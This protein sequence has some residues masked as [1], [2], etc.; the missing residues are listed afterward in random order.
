M[1]PPVWP[2]SRSASPS[3][4]PRPC[5]PSSCLVPTKALSPPVTGEH[6]QAHL[7]HAHRWGRT[8]PMLGGLPLRHATLSARGAAAR[9]EVGESGTSPRGCSPSDWLAC[10]PPQHPSTLL[11]P[12]RGA[13][14]CQPQFRQNV[15]RTSLILTWSLLTRLV[16]MALPSGRGRSYLSCRLSSPARPLTGTLSAGLQVLGG[17]R[18]CGI[19][20]LL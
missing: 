14:T 2:W 8:Q 5:R 9:A 19:L 7:S 6:H 15:T 16:R 4:C 20:S 12:S 1:S 18:L 11:P 3:P 10:I 13:P 17:R